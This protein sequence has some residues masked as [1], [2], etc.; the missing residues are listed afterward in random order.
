MHEGAK[1]KLIVILSLLTLIFF[2]ISVGSCNNSRK[3]SLERDK[4]MATRFQLEETM[5]EE[6]A[7]YAAT[8]KELSEQKSLNR[9]LQEE[10]QKV[11]EHK[12]ALEKDLK[13]ALLA[14]KSEKE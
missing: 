8:K 2:I 10:L 9:D 7:A 6:K 14:A 11:I 3:R 5:N 13:K 12:E 1:N 4:E